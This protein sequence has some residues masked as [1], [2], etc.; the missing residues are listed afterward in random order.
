MFGG[1]AMDGQESANV[2]ASSLRRFVILFL[3]CC[4]LQFKSRLGVRG[5]SP[6]CG[7]GQIWELRRAVKG[8]VTD[9]VPVLQDVKTEGLVSC[10]GETGKA[11]NGQN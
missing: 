11:K 5:Q 4:F 9:V 3:V 2:S 6:P 10:R 1:L 8:S 7:D